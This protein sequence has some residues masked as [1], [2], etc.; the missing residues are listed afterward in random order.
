MWNGAT[1]FIF[2]RTQH[3]IHFLSF[4]SL[5][6]WA[7]KISNASTV[8]GLL[9]AGQLFNTSFHHSVARI[10]RTEGFLQNVHSLDFFSLQSVFTL[11]KAQD[12]C[13]GYGG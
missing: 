6:C 4:L 1:R 7:G 8:T 12:L 2:D 5:V 3:I 9:L 13:D 10:T 11:T